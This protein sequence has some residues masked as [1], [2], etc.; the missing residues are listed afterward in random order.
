MSRATEKCGCGASIEV[1]GDY[2]HR[3]RET[4]TEW[5]AEHKHATQEATT[6]APIPEHLPRGQQLLRDRAQGPSPRT[7]RAARPVAAG[8]LR[9]DQPQVAPHS[10]GAGGWTP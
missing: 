5:R 1:A 2:D 8:Q 10:R 4:L 7:V 3:V 9:A 6:P